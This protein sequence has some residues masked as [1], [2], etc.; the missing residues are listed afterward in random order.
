MSP[1]M[2]EGML[3]PAAGAGGEMLM[4]CFCKEI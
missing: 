2:V 1:A 4:R 3:M